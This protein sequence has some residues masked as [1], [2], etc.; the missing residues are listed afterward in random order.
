MNI[1]KFVYFSSNIC[2]LVSYQQ[3]KIGVD[4]VSLEMIRQLSDWEKKLLETQELL[5][6]RGKVT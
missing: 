2:R 4:V 6:V 5:Q 3:R 1:I